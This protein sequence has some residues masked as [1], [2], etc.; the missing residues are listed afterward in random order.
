MIPDK[1]KFDLTKLFAGKNLFYT[2]LCLLIITISGL[3]IHRFLSK[4]TISNIKRGDIVS[5]S[6]YSIKY[7]G[8]VLGLPGESVLFKGV[9]YLKSQD[10][11]YKVAE[12]N[13]P[14][15]R[16]LLSTDDLR[17]NSQRWFTV[18]K[19]EIYV[20]K[21]EYPQQPEWA[22]N[23][24]SKI[25]T[26]RTLDIPGGVVKAEELTSIKNQSGTNNVVLNTYQSV[27]NNPDKIPKV[28]LLY[29]PK[30][31]N[32]SK[33]TAIFKINLLDRALINSEFLKINPDSKFFGQENRAD[34]NYIY[35]NPGRT[36][37]VEITL[38]GTDLVSHG[39]ATRPYILCSKYIDT[40][41]R[42]GTDYYENE[43]EC[44][45]QSQID[46]LVFTNLE[47]NQGNNQLEIIRRDTNTPIRYEI[48]Y[49]PQYS[50]NPSSLPISADIPVEK[51]F[52]SAHNCT[53]LSIGKVISIPMVNS[54]DS[55]FYYRLSF[56]Q[57]IRER[58]NVS[59]RLVYFGIEGVLY[60]I[61]LPSNSEFNKV[62]HTSGDLDIPLDYLV[63]KNWVKANPSQMLKTDNLPDA[64]FYY[65]G[66]YLELVPFD[67]SDKVYPSYV[68]PWGTINS[69]SCDG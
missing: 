14:D 36:N 55:N 62:I 39:F 67:R 34:I 56:P 66:I 10:K 18:G 15:H 22:G 38:N 33:I 8:R 42:T 57:S 12:N 37:G 54:P 3:Q 46:L 11:I 49:N 17:L 9:F 68:L 25:I 43:Q 35:F 5:Y 63:H 27:V 40:L 31:V 26:I 61:T 50:E 6:R 30:I 2:T 21:D 53:T 48:V 47:L 20:I 44:M 52:S 28:D 19:N 13:L 64:S 32:R 23:P 1:Y 41:E 60:E 65:P 51:R 29:P 7:A 45:E 58:G 4:P 69:S 24:N 59:Q 16:Y